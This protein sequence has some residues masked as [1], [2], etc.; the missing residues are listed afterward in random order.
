M[1]AAK[2]LLSLAGL[3]L[4]T[5][6]GPVVKNPHVEVEL[7]GQTA[8]A[9]PGSTV[10]LAVRESIVP[11]W[12]TYW[13]NAGDSGEPTSIAWTLPKGWKAGE[14]V[15]PAPHER[16]RTG[17]L[18]NYVFNGVVYL[19][20]PVEVPADAQPGSTAPI[21]AK[22]DYLV[23]ADVCVPESAELQLNLPIAA[24]TPVPDPRHGRAVTETLAAAPKAA[25]LKAVFAKSGEGLRLAVTGPE[26]KGADVGQAWFYPYDGTA[27][28]HAKPQLVERGPE[29][30][31]LTLPTGYAFARG[32]PA[33]LDGVLA[34]GPG[35]AWEVAATS[36]TAPSGA[37]G[38][39][40]P[41]ASGSPG[42]TGS[43]PGGSGASGAAGGSGALA[44][45]GYAGAAFL[46]GLILNLMPCVFPVLSI[47]AAQLVRHGEH[48]AEARAEGLA[49]LAGVVGTF[50]ALAA[51]LLALRAGG[52]AVGWGFQLQSPAVVAAL[53]LLMLAAAL[54]LSGVFE[55]GTSVQ[56]A[57]SGLAGRGGLAGAFFT[58][59]LAVVVAAPCT[60]P[61]MAGAIGWAVVQP[62]AVALLVFAA[63]GL[64]MAAPFVLIAFSPALLARLPRPGA[65]MSTV[66]Q[67]LAFPMY[68]AAA[69]L[70][71][72][73]A[74]Q[75]GPFGLPY[76]FAAAVTL[77][78]ALWL[79]GA[80]QR[81]EAEGG[82]VV[83]LRV[84]AGLAAAA[85]VALT[86]GGA[87][88]EAVAAPA[89][90]GATASVPAGGGLAAEPW[91]PERVAALRA[92][93]RPVFVDFTAAWCVTCQVN[94]RTALT[95]RAVADAFAR[96]KAVYLKADWTKRDALIA[97]TLTEH[98]RSGVPLYLVY[99]P[100][101]EPAV[102]PQLLT[103]GLV[104][105]A[106]ETAARPAA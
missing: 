58:G 50:V 103:E 83:P 31:T 70:A 98:G 92:E 12:H 61:F 85:V 96:H 94:E 56:G 76:L 73:F 47:K 19:P 60:A 67:V 102:L 71:W 77:A 46:G 7:V 66:K 79:W 24:A 45:L 33:K 25:G 9:A 55:V 16:L 36:G 54:N 84:G 44:L 5:A 29:G 30:L 17:P 63:L 37:A 82:R 62:A 6:A 1:T 72:T 105:Q 91:S 20:V 68:G 93:G 26:L 69:W 38:L 35:K 106:V 95:G 13:R 52:E 97:R 65:W 4:L 10:Y 53:G 2:F 78:F 18:V 49:F 86:V 51:A 32:A 89:A 23:C 48:P 34:L 15:W 74:Q 101:G 39:S 87:R 41:A 90:P 100:T 22:V 75:T 27:L 80:G 3:L 99:G 8:S 64:G 42:A 40:R 88:E 59:V 81:R 14:I 57:G 21:R 104:V 28:D 43:V 11:H